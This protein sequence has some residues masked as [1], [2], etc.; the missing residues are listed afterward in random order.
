MSPKSFLL[1]SELHDY[2]MAHS[3]PL[4]AV[5]Q[6]LIE[7]TAALGD[8]SGMQIA[9]EQGALLTLLAQLSGAREA[10]EIGTFTGYSALC[11]ARGLPA[12]GHLLCC[13][14]SEEWTAIGRRHWEQA[15]LADRITLRIAPA[16]ETLQALP[17]RP[18]FDYAFVDADKG[19][20]RAYAE[21]LIPRLRSGGMLIVDNVLWSGRVLESDPEGDTRAICDFNDWLA[22]DARVEA[23]MLPIA[24]G[25]TLA[26][27]K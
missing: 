19:S 24:D 9:P 21:E 18:Q 14:V 2:L 17:S 22:T 13:D 16:L 15:G 4:D 7:E 27:R 3:S 23:V 6:Q 10:V 1:T 12:E 25:L 26:R 11:I 5:Q 8:V 20:Y